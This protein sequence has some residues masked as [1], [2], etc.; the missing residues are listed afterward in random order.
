MKNK[1]ETFPKPIVL[2]TFI[3]GVLCAAGFRS[4]TI[5]DTLYPRLV[6][7]VWYFAVIGYIYFFAYRYYISSKRK[8]VIRENYLLS[9]LSQNKEITKADK[10]L[11]SYILS[12]LIKSKES[13]NYFFIFIMSILAILLDIFVSK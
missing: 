1:P 9:K 8:R 13:M 5:I 4:L 7:P 12:S 11:I 10:E 2:G 6:R 3:I